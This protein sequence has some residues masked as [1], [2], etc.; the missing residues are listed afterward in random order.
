[1]TAYTR[2]RQ[3][4]WARGPDESQTSLSWAGVETSKKKKPY[5]NIKN[6]HSMRRVKLLSLRTQ[7]LD[8]R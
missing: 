6:V 5:L 7:R 4:F 8:V 3:T 1:M 2:G